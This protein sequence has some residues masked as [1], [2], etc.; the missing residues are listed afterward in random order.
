MSYSYLAIIEA[1]LMLLLGAL[2][3]YYAT[4]ARLRDWVAH[5]ITQAEASYQ[6]IRAGGEKR[7]WV[8]SKLWEMIPAPLRGVVT[9]QLPEELV[10]GTFD[11][12]ELYAK[13]QADKVINR[14]LEDRAAEGSR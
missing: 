12:M 7:A 2:A 5:L 4:N 11:S 1:A 9:K 14:F 3:A 13:T 6:G 8:V 10:Q